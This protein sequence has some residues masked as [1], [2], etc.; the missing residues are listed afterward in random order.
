MM[1]RQ[2]HSF[3][4]LIHLGLVH[5]WWV[6]NSEWGWNSWE[7]LK[8]VKNWKMIA[9]KWITRICRIQTVWIINSRLQC[10]DMAKSLLPVSHTHKHFN[11]YRNNVLRVFNG[12]S[13]K[14]L[15]PP[16]LFIKNW[17]TPFIQIAIKWVYNWPIKF[18]K[19]PNGLG[20]QRSHLNAKSCF[21]I[22]HP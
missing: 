6:L 12:N 20:L 18:Y 16:N 1:A 8:I 2:Y 22:G 15:S 3:Y 21:Q 10:I 9:L 13:Q 5:V 17:A 14:L 11:L 19:I 7:A 4:W